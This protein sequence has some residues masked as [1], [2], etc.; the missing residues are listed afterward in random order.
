MLADSILHIT[1]GDGV[2][3]R[4]HSLKIPGQILTWREILCEGPV[5]AKVFSQPFI[6][7]RTAYLGQNFDG[8][9][10]EFR[11][12]IKQFDVF[13]ETVF[14]E[15]VLWFEYDLFCHINLA[16]VVNFL[17]QKKVYTPLFLVCSGSIE[18]SNRLLGLNELSD[19]QL[20]DH[21]KNYV[22]LLN[23]EKEALCKF[24][25]IY[26]G[27]NH[28][29]LIDIAFNE[30]KLPY[31]K[32][33]I[34]AH[35]QRFPSRLNGLNSLEIMV[36][37]AIKDHNFEDEYRLLGHLLRHQ[38]AYGFGD[39]Q[40]EAIIKKVKS[41]FVKDSKLVLTKEGTQVLED[42]ISLMSSLKDNTQFGGSLK[43]DYF[44]NPTSNKLQSA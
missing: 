25:N 14:D 22:S 23:P 26:A 15:I 34:T 18:G 29:L 17:Q 8:P 2:T 9:N 27:T 16:A 6:K 21:Y 39:V 42:K 31:L 30:E 35:L 44:Y 41:L 19:N 40:W 33:N 3:D 1:N 4:L 24:W 20:H 10:P 13:N 28:N 7:T 37:Q 43:Y 12:F 32:N 38:G 36:L 5:S 11:N